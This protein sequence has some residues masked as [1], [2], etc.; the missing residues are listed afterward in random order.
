[1]L[2]S[3]STSSA[4]APSLARGPATSDRSSAPKP[5]PY[6]KAAMVAGQPLPEGE[7]PPRI[8]WRIVS[9]G[10][11]K[12]MG[13]AVS[14]G[15]PFTEADGPDGQTVVIVN[16]TMARQF[17]PGESPVGKRV[18]AGNATDGEWATIVGVADVA[19]RIEA[20]PAQ[21][22]AF[23]AMLQTEDIEDAR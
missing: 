10:Y 3:R 6:E 9:S 21:L 23:M 16:Q 15:R 1:M 8:G 4:Q 18:M 2:R 7:T 22:D 5:E 19:L 20:G 13:L 17:W 14:S 12:A 11:F